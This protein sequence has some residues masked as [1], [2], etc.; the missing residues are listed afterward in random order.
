[1]TLLHH[2]VL[3]EQDSF[4]DLLIGVVDINASDFLGRT[5]L[6]FAVTKD[7]ADSVKFLISAGC[8]LNKKT[9]SGETALIKAIKHYKTNNI[10]L[11]LRFGADTSISYNVSGFFIKKERVFQ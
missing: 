3:V 11:L 6:H 5:A 2:A 8:D 4:V 1:M 10:R 9:F 7:N